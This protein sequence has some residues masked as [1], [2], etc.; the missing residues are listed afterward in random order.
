ML[1]ES[2]PRQFGAERPTSELDDRGQATGQ[3]L[4]GNAFLELAERVL[5][6][7]GEQLCD[8]RASSFLDNGVN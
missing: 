8:R 6:T 5:A 1:G 2:D 7:L 3:S 4:D